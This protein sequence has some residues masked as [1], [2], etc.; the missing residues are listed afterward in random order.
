MVFLSQ[1]IYSNRNPETPGTMLP[2]PG[3][4]VGLGYPPSLRMADTAAN[5]TEVL[6]LSFPF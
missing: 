4:L 1:T 6:V 3:A 5:G 2:R